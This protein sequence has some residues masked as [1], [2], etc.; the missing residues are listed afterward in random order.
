[1]SLHTINGCL[2]WCCFRVPAVAVVA[3]TAERSRASAFM[4]SRTCVSDW[5]QAAY[6]EVVR[7]EPDDPMAA[8][9]ARCRNKAASLGMAPPL[10]PPPLAT[11]GAAGAA[12]AG[13]G[14]DELARNDPRMIACRK[15]R[16]LGVPHFLW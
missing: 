16:E 12:G 5:L 14:T 3:S 13:M 15:L 2:S 8:L 1:M 7:L 11:A 10:L 6:A 9:A 4:T